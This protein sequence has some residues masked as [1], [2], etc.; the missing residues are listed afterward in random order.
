M[1]L[2]QL[3]PI[4]PGRIDVA[5]C[6]HGQALWHAAGNKDRLDPNYLL[7]IEIPKQEQTVEQSY[8]TLLGYSQVHNRKWQASQSEP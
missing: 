2:S 1:A 4:G 8:E 7:P 3:E 5:F 6:K